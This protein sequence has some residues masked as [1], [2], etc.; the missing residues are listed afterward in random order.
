MPLA[1]LH[2]AMDT[3]CS[4]ARVSA[5]VCSSLCYPATL[6]T[7]CNGMLVQAAAIFASCSL[8]TSK[9]SSLKFCIDLIWPILIEDSVK[10]V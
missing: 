7:Q 1:V 5:C 4:H 2:L 10:E 9:T 3:G 8:Y 6:H